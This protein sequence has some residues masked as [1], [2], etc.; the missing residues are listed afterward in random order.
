[1]P[2]GASTGDSIDR[3]V[4]FHS[5]RDRLL[6]SYI[7]CGVGVVGFACSGP[8]QRCCEPKEDCADGRRRGPCLGTRLR[9]ACGMLLV[10][11]C[12]AQF[13]DVLAGR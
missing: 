3:F 1:M 6:P 8:Y 12:G 2:S 10:R 5:S 7:V 9:Y 4:G 11:V 13:R